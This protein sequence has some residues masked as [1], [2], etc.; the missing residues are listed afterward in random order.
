MEGNRV[1]CN[2]DQVLVTA[3]N[4]NHNLGEWR[5]FIDSL[6][7]NLKAV[8]LLNGKALLSITVK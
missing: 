8:L 1:T 4:I 7:L 6:K 5:M 3:L 2:N